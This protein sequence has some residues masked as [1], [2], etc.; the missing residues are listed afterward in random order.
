MKVSNRGSPFID[1]KPRTALLAVLYFGFDIEN[2]RVNF[3]INRLA[4]HFLFAACG[5]IRENRQSND[6]GN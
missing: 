1:K 4:G 5:V 2:R 6:Y 3:F